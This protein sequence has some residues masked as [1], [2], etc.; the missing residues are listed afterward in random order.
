[1][2]VK[3]RNGEVILSDPPAGLPAVKGPDGYRLPAYAFAFIDR[4]SLPPPPRVDMP[5]PS[6]RDYQSDA[7][8]A[9]VRAGRRGVVVMPTGSGKTRLGLAAISGTAVPSIVL[10]PT[11]DLLRQW[12]SLLR[13]S[14]IEPG[15]IGGGEKVVRDVTV[16][17]YESAYLMRYE[18]GGRFYL[19]VADE[20]HHLASPDYMSISTDYMAPYR[21][22]LS[23]TFERRDGSHEDL[24]ESFGSVVFQLSYSD[25]AGHL[26]PYEYISVPCYMSG[27]ELEEYRREFSVYRNFVASR[28]LHFNSSEDFQR[29]MKQSFDTESRKAV[30]A[31]R[32]S[33]YIAMNSAAKREALRSI[34]RAESGNRM[35]IFCDDVDTAYSISREFLIPAVTYF[36]PRDER[37]GIL[38]RF[39]AG[40]YSAIVA[41]R[42]LDEGIDVPDATVAVVF[43]GSSNPR[44]MVQRLG[45]VLRPAPG[46]VARLYE[47]FTANSSEYRAFKNRSSGVRAGSHS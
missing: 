40:G 5:F 8:E 18:L 27:R 37:A 26:S 42:V 4:S 12:A 35:I 21:L 2:E 47:L 36:T 3:Y 6:L 1:M 10:V 41:S 43:S 44:Q 25:I 14:G 38:D 17:T 39:R 9:W 11:L 15:V 34:V 22:G 45:R 31:W 24:Y 23:A 28:G 13:E 20:A 16:S 32:E 19:M 33:R 30:Q 29:F 7:Y 46:K